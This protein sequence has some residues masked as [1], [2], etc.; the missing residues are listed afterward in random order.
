MAST[1]ANL[2]QIHAALAAKRGTWCQTVCVPVIEASFTPPGN[3]TIPRAALALPGG[4]QWDCASFD[5]Y[6]CECRK[7]DASGV[8]HRAHRCRGSGACYD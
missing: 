6:M 2:T 8:P 3:Q 4:E 7:R 5:G 1:D